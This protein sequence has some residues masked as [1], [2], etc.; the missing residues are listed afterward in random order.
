[1]KFEKI[2]KILD[3]MT[4]HSIAEVEMEDENSKIRLKINSSNQ[5]NYEIIRIPQATIPGVAPVPNSPPVASDN[6]VIGELI[7]SPIVGTFYRRPNQD[8]DSYVK[9]GDHVEDDTVVG[10]IEAMKVMN[11]IKA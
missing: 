10:I 9:V 6:I 2:R 1:M 3:L 5:G 4:K 8:S 11:E 7:C